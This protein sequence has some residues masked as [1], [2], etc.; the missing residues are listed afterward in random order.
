VRIKS[1]PELTVPDL[2]TILG[3]SGSP[4]WTWERLNAILQGKGMTPEEV[5]RKC[6]IQ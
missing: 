2:D 3:I 5:A 4:D 1:D 6:G